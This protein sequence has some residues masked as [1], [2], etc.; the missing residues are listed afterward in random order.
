[1]EVVSWRML[2]GMVKVGGEE[3]DGEKEEDE[4]VMAWEA[5]GVDED[6]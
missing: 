2:V 6:D 1:M 5:L 3:A 4:R